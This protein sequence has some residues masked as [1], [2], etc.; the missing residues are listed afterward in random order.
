MHPD[1]SDLLLRASH[2]IGAGVVDSKQPPGGWRVVMGGAATQKCSSRPAALRSPTGRLYER[3]AA[4]WRC[5]PEPGSA[6]LRARHQCEG[7]AWRAAYARQMVTS[8][9]STPTLRIGAPARVSAGHPGA[10]TICGFRA[11]TR[12]R[13]ARQ[14]VRLVHAAEACRGCR[15]CDRCT[16]LSAWIIGHVLDAA[17]SGRRGGH[18]P[19]VGAR[20]APQQ[21]PAPAASGTCRP[22]RP[23]HR[24]ARTSRPAHR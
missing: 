19:R 13:Q 11:A 22:A 20:H 2:D 17:R 15:C 3:D 18:R 14:L 1:G 8:S 4:S 23:T 12:A 6:H 21:T 9:T 24:A 10:A 5:T 16:A 7:Q